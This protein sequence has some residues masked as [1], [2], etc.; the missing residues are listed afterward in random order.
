ME[1]EKSVEV[2]S[3]PAVFVDEEIVKRNVLVEDGAFSMVKRADGEVVPTPRLP[4]MERLEVT[5]E[6]ALAVKLDKVARPE[7]VRVPNCAPPTA[8]KMPA[9][10]VEPIES[11]LVVV[12]ETKSAPVK[13]EVEEAK[14][15]CWAKRTDVVADVVV[16]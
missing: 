9:M 15:P 10:V 2:E 6:V 16:P 4:R 11:R 14:I 12:A 1:T 3:A 7:V 13:C 8:L 5:D